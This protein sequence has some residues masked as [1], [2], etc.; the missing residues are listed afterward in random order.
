MILKKKSGEPTMLGNQ[1]ERISTNP[2]AMIERGKNQRKYA[3]H[4]ARNI[5]IGS[6]VF[7]AM[8]TLSQEG[9]FGLLGR[10]DKAAER[11]LE[12]DGSESE[13]VFGGL[14]SLV[15][16]NTIGRLRDIH[17]STSENP[18]A[19]TSTSEVPVD[20]VPVTEIPLTSR[21]CETLAKPY[22][23]NDG[24]YV[25]TAVYAQNSEFTTESTDLKTL[26]PLWDIYFSADNNGLSPHNP[27]EKFND[28]TDAVLIRELQEDP[29]VTGCVI[30]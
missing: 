24:D 3:G 19:T 18:T 22:F 14:S 4:M 29:A 27:G 11:V 23:Y 5:A 9:A 2:D 7:L 28:P 16:R 13:G 30:G 25:S 12:G 17:I 15:V 21:I 8:A 1:Y 26:D 10:T 6:G 20:E